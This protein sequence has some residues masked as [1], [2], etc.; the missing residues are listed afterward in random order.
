[1]QHLKTDRFKI[2]Y[3][4]RFDI[5]Q[6]LTKKNNLIYNNI[7]L[8]WCCS[9][10]WTLQSSS[11]FFTF[12]E[13]NVLF[14]QITSQFHLNCFS[15]VSFPLLTIT[16]APSDNLWLTSVHHIIMHRNIKFLLSLSLSWSPSFLRHFKFTLPLPLLYKSKHIWF[17]TS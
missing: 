2:W 9:I 12:P 7:S 16:T 6:V 11:I 5:W 14:L 1:M 17:L 3:P 15:P 13:C 10:C 8:H 4:F